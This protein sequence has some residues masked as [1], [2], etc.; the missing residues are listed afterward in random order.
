MNL[1]MKILILA[2][3]DI[4]LYNFRKE[5]IEEL[6]KRKCQVYI[7]LPDGDKVNL[8]HNMGCIFIDTPIDRRGTNPLTDLKL[9]W[10]Y[11]K[12]M[13]NVKPDVVLTY[14]IKPIVYGGLV[15]RLNKVRF[16]TNMT[17]MGSA[18][19][20]DGIIKRIVLLLLKTSLNKSSCVFFQNEMN[21]RYFLDERI[22]TTH[23]RLIPGSGVNL[24][25]HNLEDYPED[26][27]KLIFLFIGRVMKEKGIE[28]YLAAAEL[29]KIKYPFTEFH[30]VGFCEEDY[31][32]QLQQLQE[33][34]IITFYGLQRDV[35]SFIKSAHAVILPSYHEG[36]ANVLLEAASS[37]RPV[38]ASNIPG[39]KETF[40][41]GISGF[42]FE[43]RNVESLVET[44]IKFIE[45]PYEEKKKMGLAGRVKVE[46]EFDRQIVINS[47]ME[48]INRIVNKTKNY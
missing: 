24:A 25:Y 40:D 42:G 12:I 6:I 26:E 28:E 18:I 2:N 8:L 3:N 35:H 29:I 22:V 11:R 38:L 37:G 43:I 16:I 15:C 36:M 34:N 45:L 23:N 48:E 1:N 10:Q 5:L 41:E 44:I 21:Q 27:E 47:Y 9:L 7:S 14:T 31:E 20:N 17:G 19:S 13:K 32:K 33:R 46:R 4:G 30:I 39:C